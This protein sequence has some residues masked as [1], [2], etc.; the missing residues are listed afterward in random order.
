M[1][2]PFLVLFLFGT[3]ISATDPVSVL[4]LFKEMGA[5]RRLTLLFEGESLFN[6]GTALALLLV[7]LSVLLP[8]TG[9]HESWFSHIMA[10]ILPVFG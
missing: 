2:V 3:L 6:D 5:P 9:G 1:V 10:S 8:H 7:I 4:A